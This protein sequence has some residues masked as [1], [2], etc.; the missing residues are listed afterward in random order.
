MLDNHVAQKLERRSKPGC[1]YSPLEA[2]S[3]STINRVLLM[4]ETRNA[5]TTYASQPSPHD[6]HVFQKDECQDMAL[7]LPKVIESE[8]MK[9]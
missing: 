4:V 8:S 1:I 7:S 5:T 2:Y 6:L 9:I 3:W